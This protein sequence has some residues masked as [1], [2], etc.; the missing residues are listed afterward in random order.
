VALWS[1]RCCETGLLDELRLFVHP[2]VV[3]PGIRLFGDGSPPVELALADSQAYANGV[4]SL[5]YRPAGAD[6]P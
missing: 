3:G 2:V 1:G 5:T 6:K 4:V